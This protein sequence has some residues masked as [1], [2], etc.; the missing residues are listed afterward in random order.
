MQ[1]CFSPLVCPALLAIHLYAQ[2]N[3]SASKLFKRHGQRHALDRLATPSRVFSVTEISGPVFVVSLQIFV[4]KD[5][6]CFIVDF[7]DKHQECFMVYV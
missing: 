1:Q 4:Q 2:L 7:S 6:T 5:L 3:R